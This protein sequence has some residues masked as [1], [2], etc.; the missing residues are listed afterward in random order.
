MITGKNQDPGFEVSSIAKH[1]KTAENTNE[2]LVNKENIRGTHIPR[3]EGEQR[4][5]KY[6][7]N[8]YRDR[9]LRVETKSDLVV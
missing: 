7:C 5:Q 4:C 9:K 1:N 3:H 6:S 8:K 2:T